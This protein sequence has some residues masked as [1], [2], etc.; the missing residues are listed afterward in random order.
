MY[1]Q[2]CQ[3]SACA[4]T[5][6][7]GIQNYFYRDRYNTARNVEKIHQFIDLKNLEILHY[8]NIVL[9]K[10]IEIYNKNYEQL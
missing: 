9:R 2:T 6:L 4:F 5:L 7:V 1:T 3:I 8:Q 10:R